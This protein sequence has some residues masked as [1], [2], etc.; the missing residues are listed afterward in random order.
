MC[1]I[2]ESG[3]SSSPA[4]VHYLVDGYTDVMNMND[5]QNINNDLV[6]SA[7][8]VLAILRDTQTVSCNTSIQAS[9]TGCNFIRIQPRRNGEIWG[10]Q[11]MGSTRTYRFSGIDMKPLDTMVY[12][13][14]PSNII[15]SIETRSGDLYVYTPDSGMY[16]LRGTSW[17][18]VPGSPKGLPLALTLEDRNE[19]IWGAVDS[20]GAYCYSKQNGTWKH[21][22]TA[23]SKLTSNRI[24]SILEDKNGNIIMSSDETFFESDSFVSGIFVLNGDKWT[25][26]DTINSPIKS[27]DIRCMARDSSGNIWLGSRSGVIRW[28][29]E[30]KW[31]DMCG[32]ST[33]AYRPCGFVRDIVVDSKNRVWVAGFHWG[34]FLFDQ[35]QPTCAPKISI[36]NPLKNT[37][38]K[39]NTTLKILWDYQGPVGKVK[40]QYRK[41]QSS[42][43]SIKDSIDNVKNHNWVLLNVSPS[44]EYQVR[45]SA[46]TDPLVFDTS[47]RFT[48]VDT[49]VNIPPELTPLPDTFE[50]KTNQKTTFTIHAKDVDKDTL[51]FNFSALPDWVTFKDSVITFEPKTSSPSFIFNV[52]VSDGKGGT[53]KDSMVVVVSIPTENLKKSTTDN[54]KYSLLRNGS[55]KLVLQ[56]HNNS[57]SVTASLYDLNG[58][59][60]G[61]FKNEGNQITFISHNSKIEGAMLLLVMDVLSEAGRSRIIQKVILQ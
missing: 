46:V 1:Y 61:E 50:V 21:Y 32:T 39:L 26:Y 15:S 52:T 5:L 54:Y 10:F 45:I 28:D 13:P 35:N 49:G 4:W 11:R 56:L 2:S 53:V 38:A 44:T 51:R 42:W 29:G 17:I 41:G 16:I 47:A 19:N 59:K 25:R 12:S 24:T 9:I 20:G 31:D 18:P 22:S 7:Q 57:A 36:R 14:I 48:I 55:G 27:C 58:Q 33:S 6:I 30:N 37:V 60:V 8:E 34:F 23:N 3:V 43:V 40:L